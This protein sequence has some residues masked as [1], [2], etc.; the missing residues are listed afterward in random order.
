M[1]MTAVSPDATLPLY[2]GCGGA[3]YPCGGETIS[4]YEPIG[5]LAMRYV[6]SGPVVVV[7]IVDTVTPTPATAWLVALSY[8]RPRIVG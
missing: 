4:V 6:P 3:E 5:T 7:R 2:V 1:S 8:A